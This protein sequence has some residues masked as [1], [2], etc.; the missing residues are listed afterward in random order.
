MGSWWTLAP[1]EGSLRRV[2]C[3]CPRGA[4]HWFMT[5]SPAGCCSLNFGSVAGRNAVCP[6][7]PSAMCCGVGAESL[8]RPV[9]QGSSAA[10]TAPSFSSDFVGPWTVWR[11]GNT[12]Y[13]AVLP[14]APSR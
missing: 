14:P 13:S 1:R 5:F 3:P 11:T 2:L 12:A 7:T 8:Q 6:V 4:S 10:S 9:I